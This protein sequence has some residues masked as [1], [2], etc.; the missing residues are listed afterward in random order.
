SGRFFIVQNSLAFDLPRAHVQIDRERAAAL[1]VA[2]SEIGATLNVLLSETR[3]SRFDLDNRS[4]D[5]IPQ[6]D[7][8]FRLD[9]DSLGRFYVRSVAGRMVPLSAVTKV[10]TQAG[11]VAI[12][13][14]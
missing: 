14:G 7:D 5:V 8:A 6:V 12:D 2:V 11:P 9:A 4:Y 1:G 3:I 10:V 13:A